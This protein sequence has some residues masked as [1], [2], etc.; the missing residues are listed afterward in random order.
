MIMGDVRL[1][2]TELLMPTRSKC[3][4]R[5]RYAP[6]RRRSIFRRSNTALP[7]FSAL[8]GKGQSM[9]DF[10]PYIYEREDGLFLQEWIGNQSFYNGE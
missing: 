4:P 8:S 5:T 6:K 7:F 9:G 10:V 1:L 2:F 3:C